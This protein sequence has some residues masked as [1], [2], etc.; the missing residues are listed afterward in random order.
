MKRISIWVHGLDWAADSLDVVEAQAGKFEV[1]AL[2]AG[3]NVELAAEQIAQ[4]RPQIVSVSTEA[5]ARE[6]CAALEQRRP[7]KTMYLQ[8]E[9]LFGPEGIERVATHPDAEMVVSAAVGVV[10]LPATYKAIE[11]GKAYRAREQ[12][13]SGC[14]RG[15]SDGGGE[16]PRC[17][18]PARR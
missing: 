5:A 6:L 9:I 17:R 8:P 18:A 1:V 3:S 2:A 11:A 4:H 10:G 7:P 14:G 13:S 16:A 15:S 12:R